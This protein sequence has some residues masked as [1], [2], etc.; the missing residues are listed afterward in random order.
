VVS[1]VSVVPTIVP[2]IRESWALRGSETRV[3]VR[4]KRRPLQ[5]R[6]EWSPPDEQALYAVL[7]ESARVDGKPRQRVVGYLAAIREGELASALAVE[8]FWRDVD[9]VL[10][11]LALDDK[12]PSIEG[13]IAATV[14]RPDPVVLERTRREINAWRGTV[15]AMHASRAWRRRRVS[16]RGRE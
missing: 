9:R 2:T 13:K 12:R 7:V 15:S 1:F 6:H 5:H 16:M 3:F 14:P 4:W 8:R 10:D 11:T